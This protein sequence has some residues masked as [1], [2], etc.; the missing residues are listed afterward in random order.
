MTKGKKTNKVY[1]KEERK[2]IVKYRLL[3]ATLRE[4]KEKYGASDGTLTRWESELYPEIFKE[5]EK[6][7][8]ERPQDEEGLKFVR[9]GSRSGYWK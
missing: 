2:E 6:E 5:M 3:G 8:R 1:T 7:R 4:V 9:T